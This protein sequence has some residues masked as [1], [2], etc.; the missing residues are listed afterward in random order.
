MQ[1]R[2]KPRTRVRKTAK[3]LTDYSSVIECTVRNLTGSGAC[4]QVPNS[5]ALPDTFE[6]T[7]DSFRSVRR[8]RVRWRSENEIGV[9]FSDTSS[10]AVA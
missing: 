6:L 10:V 1:E 8:C 9:S 2:N 3:L 5:V 4:L 7:F